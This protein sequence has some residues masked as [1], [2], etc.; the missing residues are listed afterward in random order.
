MRREKRDLLRRL[1]EAESRAETAE[2]ARDDI[3]ADTSAIYDEGTQLWQN[4]WDQ[5]DVSRTLRFPTIKSVIC[6]SVED[7]GGNSMP[8]VHSFGAI[9]SGCTTQS[10]RIKGVGYTLEG[11]VANDTEKHHIRKDAGSGWDELPMM[12]IVHSASNECEGEVC[13]IEVD[14]LERRAELYHSLKGS[15]QKLKPIKVWN[16]LPEK[17]WIAVAFK[18]N[19]GREAVLMP[20]VHWS[21]R[22]A[23][24][25]T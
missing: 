23:S 19:S 7:S 4:V 8:G 6:S 15:T 21:M 2:R 22:T 1:A 10:I 11:L 18:R 16:N 17:V 25:S 12:E 20:C 9:E 24:E 3:L 14:M 5:N 13:T